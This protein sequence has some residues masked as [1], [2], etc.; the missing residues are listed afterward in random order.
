MFQLRDRYSDYQKTAIAI[1]L[2][3]SLHYLFID[4]ELENGFKFLRAIEVKDKN[5]I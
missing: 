2:P 1:V 3:R 5:V 4:S